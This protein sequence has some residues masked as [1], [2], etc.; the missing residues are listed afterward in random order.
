MRLVYCYP[1]LPA[2]A[3]RSGR[4]HG[5]DRLRRRRRCFS[6]HQAEELA[7][8][9]VE[10]LL[11][12]GIIFHKLPGIFATLADALTPEAVPGA[13]LLHQVLRDTQIDQIAFLR[14]ALAVYDVELGFAEGRR[15]F[16]FH[17]FDLGSIAGD[18]LAV[19]DRGDAADV[20]AHA[21]VELQG[22]AA[23]G[24]FRI[25][26]HHADLFADLVDENQTGIR[27]RD[28]TGEL[29]HGLRHQARMHAHKAVTHFAVKLSLGHQ[30]GDRIDY[31][32]VDGAGAD[33]SVRDFKR[34]FAIIGLGYEQVVHVHAELLGVHGIERVL[35]VNVGGHAA[36]FLRFGDHLQGDGRFAGRLRPEN[37]RDAATWEA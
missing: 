3:G 14:N 30:G 36:D 4:Y 23:G 33:Q 11:G 2:S 10:L 17:D 1:R 31:Q 25:A 13:A 15:H 20:G 28:D 12:V 19:L 8:V 22:A 37:F 34:L 32:H 18:N 21:R 29:A 16:V 6:T 24:G 27:L 7:Q 9:G 35:D 26:E 5:G